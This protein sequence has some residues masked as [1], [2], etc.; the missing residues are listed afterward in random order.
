MPSKLKPAWKTFYSLYWK[1]SLFDE[2]HSVISINQKYTLCTAGPCKSRIIGGKGK[3]QVSNPRDTSNNLVL[4]PY[5]GVFFFASPLFEIF[6][7][8]NYGI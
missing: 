4:K 6:A 7:N 8:K 1:S 2:F 5:E 3:P